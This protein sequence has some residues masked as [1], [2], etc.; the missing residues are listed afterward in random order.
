MSKISK[1]KRVNELVEH[2]MNDLSALADVTTVVGAPIQTASGYQ[3]IPVSKVMLGYLSGG[4]DLGETKVIK[5]GESTPFAGGSGAIVALK[6]AGF[7]L[8]D[9]NGCRFVHAGGDPLDNLIDKAAELLKK[10][11]GD[12]AAE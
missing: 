12:N 2:S 11:Q 4:G 1:N 8:D 7:I 6:P 9:G 10:L 5:E 3:V